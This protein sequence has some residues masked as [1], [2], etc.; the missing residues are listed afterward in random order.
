MAVL[1]TNASNRLLFTSDPITTNYT[2]YSMGGWVKFLSPTGSAYSVMIARTNPGAVAASIRIEYNGTSLGIDDYLPS[3]GQL[4]VAAAQGL[5]SLFDNWYH[6]F[7]VRSSSNPTRKLYLNGVVPNASWTQNSSE[8]YASGSSGHTS[9]IDLGCIYNPAN[10]AT[11]PMN[12][13]Y[14]DMRIYGRS[15]ADAEVY[16]IYKGTG[17]DGLLNGCVFRA[18][19]GDTNIGNSAATHGIFEHISGTKLTVVG[20]PTVVRDPY[21]PWIIGG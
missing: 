2:Q 15:L 13:E 19:L 12:G 21:S 18:A 6:I 11:S 16:D 10:V 9:R 1:V 14:F 20:N 7:M 8:T 17:K 5:P 4:Y 3:G